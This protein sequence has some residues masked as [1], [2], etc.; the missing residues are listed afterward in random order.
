MA[1]WCWAATSK[2]CATNSKFSSVTNQ[3]SLQKRSAL[4]EMLL[5][6]QILLSNWHYWTVI[7]KHFAAPTGH[8]VDSTHRH[9]SKP[10]ADPHYGG[11]NRICRP[12]GPTHEATIGAR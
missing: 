10:Y 1:F 8:F 2:S 3:V 12:H 5:G 9:C 7:L 11:R 4:S 6:R